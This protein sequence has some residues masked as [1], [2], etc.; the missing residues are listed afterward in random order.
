MCYVEVHRFV[1]V[2]QTILIRKDPIHLNK[3]F[4]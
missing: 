3:Y 1:L 2:N 4:K